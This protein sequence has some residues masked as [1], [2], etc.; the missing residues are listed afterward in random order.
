MPALDSAR[1]SRSRWAGG[2]LARKLRNPNHHPSKSSVLDRGIGQGRRRRPR[3]AVPRTP[4]APPGARRVHRPT[5]SPCPRAPHR[6][7]R[8]KLLDDAVVDP[9]QVLALQTAGRK[10]RPADLVPL[11]PQ[12]RVTQIPGAHQ[13][14]PFDQRR[15]GSDRTLAR[16]AVIGEHRHVGRHGV[17]PQQRGL[18]LAP[19]APG[20][21]RKRVDEMDVDVH[22][23][24][25]RGS[26]GREAFQEAGAGGPG[27]DN[28]HGQ[29]HLS[30][31]GELLARR[32]RPTGAA[33][34]R[35]DRSRGRRRPGRPR[36]PGRQPG[37]RRRGLPPR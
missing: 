32:P 2:P 20:A 21:G 37:R 24:Q 26:A 15:A 31:R 6:D 29:H 12:R 4:G 28:G 25:Q 11:R 7:R 3:G 23:G 5:P 30:V 9:R 36:R 27:A 16:D 35:L 13:G 33:A 8:R 34:A 18:L 10:C 19:D 22:T 14:G 1:S 17:H